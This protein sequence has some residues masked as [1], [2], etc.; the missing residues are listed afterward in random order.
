LPQDAAQLGITVGQLLTLVGHLDDT[1]GFDTPRERFR[2]FLIERVTD[3]RVARGFVEQCQRSIGEQYHRAVQDGIVLLGRFLGFET[4]FGAYQRLAGAVKFD[5]QWRSRRRLHVVLEVRTDQT[6]RPDLET[7][8]RSLAAL[9]L[10][11]HL[12]ADARRIG[13]CV[14]TPLYA[15]RR[16]E[17]AAAAEGQHDLRVV[18]SRSLLWLADMVEAGRLKHEDIVRLLTPGSSV[19]SLIDLLER[20]AEGE[21]QMPLALTGAPRTESEFWVGVIVGDAMST[22]EQIVES[23]IAKRQVLGAT[24]VG[25]LQGSVR[26]DNWV[27]FYVP[28][29]GV[30]GHAQVAMLLEDRAEVIRESN[31]FSRL[32]RLKNI[33]LYDSPVPM[34]LVTELHLSAGLRELGAAGTAL[35]P[36][37]KQE[38]LKCTLFREEVDPGVD[39]DIGSGANRRERV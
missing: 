23:V 8:S 16:L 24:F 15:G 25:G 11:T 38:F 1:P 3:A 33:E 17:D 29:K 13:L 26:S 28:G 22:P 32:L 18:S 14:V 10:T 37:T 2:R 31:R 30:V 19:E 12:E 34:D 20:L 6:P 39:S 5:G 9:T 27:C 21:V 35:A 4:E 36:L 7:L